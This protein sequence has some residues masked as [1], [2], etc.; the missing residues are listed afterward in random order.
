MPRFLLEQVAGQSKARSEPRP[1]PKDIVAGFSA[2]R[3]RRNHMTCKRC[4]HTALKFGCYGKRHIQRYRCSTCKATFSEYEPKLGTHYTDPEI[5]AKALA[6]MLEGMSV[7]AIS[8]IVDMDKNTVLSLMLTAGQ[9]AQA[10]FDSRVRAIPAKIVQADE[11]WAFCHTK[12]VRTRP[13]DAYQF[14]TELA[15]RVQG[16]FQL[17]TDG[18]GAYMKPVE[19]LLYSRSD[20]AQLV[21]VFQSPANAGPDWYGTGSILKQVPTEVFGLPERRH[22]STSFVERW[23]LGLRMHLRRFTRLTNAHSKKL[24]NHKAAISLYMAWYNFVRV[25]SS[26]RVTAAMEAG[27]TDH[28]WSLAELLS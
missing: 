16:H 2:Q 11:V 23:N 1:R 10:L 27:L 17:T 28:V 20:Y 9:R 5:A 25:H 26:L 4:N 15:N 6:M 3:K 18:F 21:K 22:I 12:E 14:I 24:E 8:R 7:R 13:G 19:D